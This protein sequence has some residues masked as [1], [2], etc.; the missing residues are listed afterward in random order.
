MGL[1][2]L[3]LEPSYRGVGIG[4]QVLLPCAQNSV[5]F[6]AISAYFSLGGLKLLAP[7]LD[8]IRRKNGKVRVVMSLQDADGSEFVMV[9]K[10]KEELSDRIAAIA[11]QIEADLSKIVD[12]LEQDRLAT[13]G[14]MLESGLLKIRVAAV[15]DRGLPSTR[16]Y[17]HQKSFVFKDGAGDGIATEGSVNFTENGLGWH[18][19]NLRVFSSWETASHFKSSEAYFDEVWNGK[20]SE[21]IVEDLAGDVLQRL[22]DA[23]K[24]RQQ[25]VAPLVSPPVG[26]APGRGAVELF[27]MMR[28]SPEFA[29]FNTTLV[30]LYP[31]QE[32]AL[33]DAA[34]RSRI[35]VMFCDDV[36]LGKTIEAG[37]TLSYG[38]KFL[39]WSKVI[40]LV[41]A[42]LARQW[43]GELMEKIGIDALRVD[44]QQKSLI[45]WNGSI[46][47]HVATEWPAGV[48][49]M[50]SQL[51][52]RSAYF[53]DIFLRE[54]G[55]SDCLMLDEAHAAR[56]RVLPSGDPDET[57][58]YK[59]ISQVAHSVP[60]LMLL[61][62]TPMQ[63][64]QEELV[65]LLEMIGLPK[66]WRDRKFFSVYHDQ[67]KVRTFGASSAIVL[68]QGHRATKRLYQS[69]SAVDAHGL[70]RTPDAF[71]SALV[72][73]CITPRLI[74]R[75]TREA[76]T[77]I[78]YRFPKRVVHATSLAM[79]VRT[80]AICDELEGY[81]TTYFGQTEAVL[82]ERRNAIGYLSA[83][84]FQRLVSSFHSAFATLSKRKEKLDLWLA[85]DF[86]GIE[87]EVPDDDEDDPDV[88]VVAELDENRRRTAGV[89]CRQ[90]LQVIR[91]ILEMLADYS[92]IKAKNDPKI[93]AL[94]A[95]VAEILGNSQKALIFSRYT[96]TTEA[97]VR[98]LGPRF[99]AKDVGYGYYS[100]GDCWIQ[101]G[102]E[103]IPGTKND[104]VNSLR[105]G[106]IN[107]VI[108]TDAAS[109]G[110]NL[111]SACHLINVDVPWNPARLEQRFG[112]I[113]RLGQVADEVNFYNLW[114]PG[115]IEERMYGAIQRRSQDIGFSVG[116]MSDTVGTSIRKHLADRAGS[117]NLD[118]EAA[119]DV[120]RDSQQ[121]LNLES[122]EYACGSLVEP[123]G[124]G[125]AFRAALLRL[126]SALPG[127]SELPGGAYGF[128]GRIYTEQLAAPVGETITLGSSCFDG[129]AFKEDR[130]GAGAGVHV[131]SRGAI[132][133]CACLR[134]DGGYRLLSPPETAEVAVAMYSG[135]AVRLEL[136]VDVP[137]GDSGD[138]GLQAA[139]DKRLV[140]RIKPDTIVFDQILT[141]HAHPPARQPL[142]I[143]TAPCGYVQV[144]A[145]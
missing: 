95:I 27:R 89:K 109:E 88:T 124:Q 105:S 37:A 64:Q 29:R 126:L 84:Y 48:Y 63:S 12:A 108:C 54:I 85:A 74:I 10:N 56:R 122:I 44:N 80:Q 47:G 133:L 45:A 117:H 96:D 22:S 123:D 46:V 101:L 104:I 87:V 9:L 77:R 114:Y 103:K 83:I 55:K 120:V 69:L 102:G 130:S 52:S 136:S 138:P 61:T 38:L 128:E 19:E 14:Y 11:R 62:A 39:S 127:A 60:N 111:Q 20:D 59:L 81:I 73:S 125:K 41:P 24:K 67:F 141:A 106:R 68:E 50:S 99:A 49:I 82:F 110:L 25:S 26:A 32:R 17:L 42:G 135:K 71:K 5:S 16:G 33:V 107:F 134:V 121:Q 137:E 40:I 72:T 13:L 145:S 75:N 7:G 15:L 78:G 118:L 86:E 131:I 34:S 18:S 1:R 91:P 144:L 53:R 92:G 113:D 66:T 4:T 8:A 100:G 140:G 28:T 58:I 112:R 98:V 30:P 36:G 129:A 142:S 90:E 139:M 6:D 79:D 65:A 3:A 132:P 116:V 23:L 76:L 51:A 70:T 57:L 2:Q 43:Q 143:A 94:E 35:R 31:H 93:K 97:I 119:L 115:S 21:L